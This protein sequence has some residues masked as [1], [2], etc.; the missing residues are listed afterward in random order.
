MNVNCFDKKEGYVVQSWQQ[1]DHARNGR[2]VTDS[3]AVAITAQRICV[4]MDILLGTLIK[5]LNT[6]LG[7]MALCKSPLQSSLKYFLCYCLFI[8][9]MGYPVVAFEQIDPQLGP[10]Y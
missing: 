4:F 1:H 5:V 3:K 10:T 6:N 7:L 8:T 2:S 9:F